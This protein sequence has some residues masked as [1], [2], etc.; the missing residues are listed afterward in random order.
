MDGLDP[1]LKIVISNDKSHLQVQTKEISLEELKKKCQ[2]EFGYDETDIQKM[3]LWYIDDDNDKNLINNGSDLLLF[4]KE[5]EFSKFSINLTLQL[6]NKINIKE[7]NKIEEQKNIEINNFI[8][9]ANKD[10]NVEKDIEIKKLQKEIDFLKEEIN[11]HKQRNKNI[12]LKYEEVL[13]EFRVKNESKK[14]NEIIEK[15]NE[16]N[17]INSQGIEDYKINYNDMHD[18][19]KKEIYEKE[20][21]QTKNSNE[22]TNDFVIIKESKN[23]YQ[24]QLSNNSNLN[25]INVNNKLKDNE[26]KYNLKKLEFIN[27]RCKKCNKKTIKSIFKCIICDNYYLCET[28]HKANNKNKFHEHNEYF[29]IIYPNGVQNQ[30]YKKQNEN[31]KYNNAVNSFYA[32]LR[33]IFFDQNSNITTK[34]INKKEIKALNK[35]SK[36]IDSLNASA[37][38]YFSEYQK[39]YINKGLENDDKLREII[40]QKINIVVNNI[41]KYN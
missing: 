14:I 11:Y 21:K 34:E 25:D 23:N 28:C 20:E 7:E 32:L 18:Y 33:E 41:T 26:E 22:N 9:E 13:N 15:N 24:N 3:N 31:I 10:N 6:S 29:Q 2:E 16:I 1:E 12:I 4:A 30:L 27:N 40:F 38:E 17:N 5:M 35:I 19:Y 39:I 37:L 8:D 36:E